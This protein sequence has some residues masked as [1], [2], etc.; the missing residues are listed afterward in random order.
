[1]VGVWHNHRRGNVSPVDLRET[2]GRQTGM[3]RVTQKATNEQAR[4]TIDRF[5]SGCLK[6]RLWEI[7]GVNPDPLTVRP[8]EIP[9]ICQEACN[10]LVAE[11]RKV[12]KSS[13]TA[14]EPATA[15]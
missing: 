9:L 12:V 1:M 7:D 11:I 14:P 4:H 15:A 5:C 8:N 2:L 6:Y 10:L 3:Y 13:S